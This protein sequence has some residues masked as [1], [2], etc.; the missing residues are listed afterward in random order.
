MASASLSAST[1]KDTGKGVARKLRA[2]GKVPGVVYG[3]AREPLS[4]ELDNREL[5]RLLEKIAAASTV[6]D[7]SI[8]GTARKTLIREIQRHPLNP[9][10]VHIDFLEL[11]AGEKVTVALRIAFEGTPVGVRSDGGIFE[12]TLHEVEIEVDPA[13]IP[14]RLVVDVTDLAIGHS[15]HVS[16]IKLPDGVELV[17]DPGVTI[18]ICS[19]PRAEEEVVPAVGAETAA[20]AEPELIRKPKE[21][22]EEGEAAAE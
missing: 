11:V 16:D 22:D 3:H 5:T 7:L 20:V 12:E 9:G 4:L 6:I 21:G 15:L 17:T 2:A 1:R 13:S 14:D 19:A 10:I 18:C 8:D